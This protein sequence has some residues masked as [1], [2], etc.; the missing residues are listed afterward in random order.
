MLRR[1]R[2]HAR[3]ARSHARTSRSAAATNQIERKTF[4][5]PGPAVAGAGV[6]DERAR[7][8]AAYF[9]RNNYAVAGPPGEVI[10]FEGNISP[11]RGTA[12]YITFC[13][14]V[15]LGSAALV[16][17]IAQPAIGDAAYWL[18]ALSPAAG[19]Y[20]WRNAARKESV[21]VKI[22]TSDDE[23]TSDITIEGDA[24]EIERCARELDMVEKG[25]IKVKGLLEPSRPAA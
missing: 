13:A 4:E 18:T 25:K 7:S 17:S 3:P 19:A 22:V 23:S 14:F 12:A 10:T 1:W 15:G 11:E 6:L 9:K 2:G 5:V 21:R 16:L 20:Y 8:L 24:N